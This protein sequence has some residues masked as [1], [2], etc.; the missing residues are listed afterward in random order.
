MIH[1]FGYTPEHYNPL[2]D[3]DTRP[4]EVEPVDMDDDYD[5]WEDN[6]NDNNQN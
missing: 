4:E 3:D 6:D 2:E 1:P 5:G